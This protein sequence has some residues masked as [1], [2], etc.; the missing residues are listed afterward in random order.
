MGINLRFAAS[1]NG[2]RNA[3]PINMGGGANLIE[4]SVFASNT[5]TLPYSSWYVPGNGSPAIST[6]DYYLTNGFY[7]SRP[8]DLDTMGSEGATIKAREGGKRYVWLVWADHQGDFAASADLM[9]G[10]SNDP[11]ILPCPTTLRTLYYQNTTI[12]VVDQNGTTQN[13]FIVYQIASLVYNPDPGALA[14]FYIYAEGVSLSAGLAHQLSLLTTTDFQ[15][16]TLQGPAIPTTSVNGWSSYGRPKRLGVNN[17]EVYA[18]GKTDGSIFGTY[19]YVSTDGWVWTLVNSTQRF[20]QNTPITISGQLYI[21]AK[22]SGLVN[23]YLSLYPVDANHVQNGSPV[24]IS[25]GFGPTGSDAVNVFP[26]PTYFQ[27][28]DV[29]EEDGLATM[30]VLRGFPV[31]AHDA[32]NFGPYLGNSPN[33]YTIDAAVNSQVLTVYP[34]FPSGV[35]PLAV[36]FRAWPYLTSARPAITSF[37]TG[38]GADGTYNVTSAGG[39]MARQSMIVTTNGGLW[40]QFVDIYRVVTDA[41]AAANAAPLGV[42]ASCAA[43]VVTIQWNNALPHQNYRVYRGTAVGTQTTLIG[44]VTGTSI[45]DTPTAGLQY[46]YK[47]VTM[48]SGEQKSRVVSVY[49]SNNTAMVN[50]HVNRVINDGGDVTKINMTFLASADSW[51][52]SNDAYKYVQWWADARFGVKLDGSGFI[53]KVYCLGTTYMPRGGDY[54]PT[55]SDTY[56][57]TSSN[58]SYS[59]TSFRGTTPSWV[60]NANTAHGYFG[61]GRANNMQR[62]N[63]I[64][65]LAAYQRPSGTG[66]AGLFG[67]GQFEGLYLTQDTGASGNINFGMTAGLGGSSAYTI[68]TAAFSGATTPRVAAGVFNGSTMTTYL[69]GVAGTPVNASAFSN[70]NLLNPSVLRGSLTALSGGRPVLCSGSDTGIKNSNYNINTLASFTGA[71]LAVFNKGLSQSLVQSWGA[72]YA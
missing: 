69:D 13:S 3:G 23:D 35:P 64:T 31:G 1:P 60:N 15:T 21:P 4:R 30:Y 42:K 37:G 17:W 61:G 27:D 57:S 2:T 38:T 6:S 62:W 5:P 67:Y 66:V 28:V 8:Y 29:Y 9:I 24:R 12:N 7:W 19:K 65:L 50:K 40:H 25:N 54:T 63:E 52:T 43:G 49:A 70:P 20:Y 53:S 36:G 71:G 44:D 18:F 47:V 58:T 39:N 41:T 10:Y 22:E 26:G 34:P 11:Q 72:L 45:T 32:T 33:F 46:F 68:S 14:P 48:N 55:T 56:P 51:L 16:S 59:A